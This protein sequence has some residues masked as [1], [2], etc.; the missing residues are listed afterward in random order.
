VSLDGS[1]HIE[2]ILLP[3]LCNSNLL[4]S[5]ICLIA[6]RHTRLDLATRIA[7]VLFKSVKSD[8]ATTLFKTPQEL[9]YFQ[10]T[11]ILCMWSTS[12]GQTPLS[13]DSWLLSGFAIQ[14]A[15]SSD[16]FKPVA[17][18][19]SRNRPPQSDKRLYKL[20]SIW[21]HICLVHLQ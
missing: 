19:G 13:L 1:L 17:G 14:H 7:P 10:A 8:L 5:A 9:E 16:I 11:L 3:K 21:N 20:W 12:A 15:F 18:A 2:E 4:L 6:I